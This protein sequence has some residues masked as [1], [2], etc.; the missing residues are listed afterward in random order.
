MKPSQS[1]SPRHVGIGLLL[2]GLFLVA[3]VFAGLTLE[4]LSRTPPA[5]TRGKTEPS[6]LVTIRHAPPTVTPA[7]GTLDGMGI[8][9]L[10]AETPPWEVTKDSSGPLPPGQ[11]PAW[12]VRPPPPDP[13]APAPP[14]PIEPPDPATHT[15]PMDNPG[16]VNGARPER[17]VPGL[18]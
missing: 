9:P 6:A 8:T 1:S 7:P 2:G 16:G 14:A 12:I 5:P 3:G 10:P 13:S 18:P 15:P 11:V 4:G 17:S